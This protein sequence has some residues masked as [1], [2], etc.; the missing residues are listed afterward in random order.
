MTI[1]N[2]SD[3]C[4]GGKTKN[5]ARACSS[6][7]DKESLGADNEEVLPDGSDKARYFK[8]QCTPSDCP[9]FGEGDI[10]ASYQTLSTYVVKWSEK[11]KYDKT[12]D[13]VHCDRETPGSCK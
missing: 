8:V 11:C 7:S 1:R 6:G 3:D 10:P 5:L 2:L 9:V 13:K 4:V 12:S